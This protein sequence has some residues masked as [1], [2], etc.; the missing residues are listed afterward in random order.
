MTPLSGE[1][2][3][4]N[5]QNLSDDI[6]K[7]VSSK[8]HEEITQLP[9]SHTR[10]EV[11]DSGSDQIEKCIEMLV[12]MVETN[13]REAEY[14][15]S[16]ETSK[17]DGKRSEDVAASSWKQANTEDY[18]CRKGDQTT[19]I[20]GV[21]MALTGNSPLMPDKGLS[22][23]PCRNSKERTELPTE[24][25]TA[26][27]GEGNESDQV[28]MILNTLIAMVDTS[29]SSSSQAGSVQTS[30]EDVN[31]CSEEETDMAKENCMTKVRDNENDELKM[32]VSTFATIDTILPHAARNGS[33]EKSEIVGGKRNK[34]EGNIIVGNAGANI[35][36]HGTDNH[37]E[38]S[39]HGPIAVV[40]KVAE[41]SVEQTSTEIKNGNKNDKK[42][43]TSVV[44]TVS[45]GGTLSELDKTEKED[46]GQRNVLAAELCTEQ[47]SE[48][49]R[50]SSEDNCAT[51]IS[52]SQKS[53]P[54][55]TLRK[56]HQIS[57]DNVSEHN[58]DAEVY[59][60]EPNNKDKISCEGDQHGIS[61][62]RSITLV[63]TSLLGNESTNSDDT[64][65]CKKDLNSN[66]DEGTSPPTENVCMKAPAYE[67]DNRDPIKPDEYLAMA[68]NTVQSSSV[69][70]SK[71]TCSNNT[72]EI[73]LYAAE[74]MTEGKDCSKG[75][76]DTDR[77]TEVIKT[78][79]PGSTV[80]G[81]NEK[82]DVDQKQNN[83]E[84]T[85]LQTGESGT[86]DIQHD[87]DDH[88]GV[89]PSKLDHMIETKLP[90]SVLSSPEEH[91][92]ESHRNIKTATLMTD[93]TNTS[94]RSDHKDNNSEEHFELSPQLKINV[95][96]LE[97]KEDEQ[98][99]KLSKISHAVNTDPTLSDCTISCS[100][101]ESE[102][103]T[104]PEKNKDDT[105]SG[106]TLS[107]S[108]L[109]GTDET[110][111]QD[112][113]SFAGKAF[114]KILS[115]FWPK[116]RKSVGA[117]ENEAESGLKTAHEFVGQEKTEREETMPQRADDEEAPEYQ[118]SVSSKSSCTSDTDKFQ[119][120]EQLRSSASIT[121]GTEIAPSVGQKLMEV[122]EPASLADSGLAQNRSG[123]CNMENVE[124]IA[125]VG[126]L[127]E[128]K[129]TKTCEETIENGKEGLDASKKSCR[130]ENF[131]AG[132]NEK[133]LAQE[134]TPNDTVSDE[135]GC[136]NPLNDSQ[137]PVHIPEVIDKTAP[138]NRESG[139][140][141]SPIHTS[142]R[143]DVEGVSVEEDPQTQQLERAEEI[144]SKRANREKGRPF[145]SDRDLNTTDLASPLSCD[146]NRRSPRTSR[147][148]RRVHYPEMQ[149]PKEYVKR[150][151]SLKKIFRDEMLTPPKSR[152]N[153]VQLFEE[154]TDGRMSSG[155]FVRNNTGS[156]ASAMQKF[157]KH[158]LYECEL[159]IE[160]QDYRQLL[161]WKKVNFGNTKKGECCFS[162]ECQTLA[163]VGSE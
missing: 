147:L 34:D 53:L 99:Q 14:E 131:S 121:N 47:T 12:A 21:K 82:S 64:S 150:G 63:D 38:T 13:E 106:T 86:N 4:T 75:N 59:I 136:C 67:K 72:T 19:S 71:E 118:R 149:L 144:Y 124:K 126:A 44:D 128:Q 80:I 162:P 160:L 90:E 105:E 46:G 134:E 157:R 92:D 138:I 93:E 20:G 11:V 66:S 120:S 133:H 73:E 108:S 163:S 153:K 155:T 148:K 119:G 8:G 5:A 50:D 104:N 88:T 125:P 159:K 139:P 127:T 145:Q 6:S 117:H 77:S 81:L 116:E 114:S 45:P 146:L 83:E 143:K 28:E 56:S 100:D 29:L 27:V 52:T 107:D 158:E 135:K 41:L 70:T 32:R 130:V 123:K 23:S 65:A 31:N 137:P 16:D 113:Q 161:K 84:R 151:E 18:E 87:E 141:K 36:N 154:S 129:P 55:C 140:S 132:V 76:N 68:S 2:I 49:S 91:P 79:S 22:K 103:R 25:S 97:E 40:A 85:A 60:D 111:R 98:S 115:A 51:H 17:E 37:M 69:E 74:E 1:A 54:E 110:F 39:T 48:E 42:D 24:K 10:I 152:A 142:H 95:N 156:T 35:E 57:K 33:N 112:R 30:K 62:D 122:D 96:V 109:S 43:S 94:V 61:T 15:K 26:N 58:E 3:Q 7:E 102:P 78:I 89:S 9:S 101:G